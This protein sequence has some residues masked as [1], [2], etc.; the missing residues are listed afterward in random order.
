[1][2]RGWP[3]QRAGHENTWEARVH[4][5]LIRG[6]R[7]VDGT[8]APERSG[9]VAIDGG[10]ITAVGRV[11][12]PARRVIEADGA[13]V[14][15]GFVDTHSHFDGQY[16]WDDRLDPCFS[17]GVTS[18]IAGNCGVGFAPARPRDQRM[19]MALMEG[20]EDIPGAVLEEGLDWRWESFTD[21][22]DRIDERRFTMDVGVQLPHAPLRVYVMGER[23]A[24]HEAATAEDIEAMRRLLREGLDAGALGFSTGR[25]LGHRSTNGEHPPGTFAC[26]DELLAM[27]SVLRESGRGVFQMVPCGVAGEIFGAMATREER[28]VEH[29]R[30]VRI[31][32]AANRP[33]IYTLVQ[34]QSDPD[35]WKLML[36]AS[37]QAH[38]EG[39][40]VHPL[41]SARAVGGLTLLE[42]YHPF[43]LR[44]A[45][46]EIAN[47]PLAERAAAMR[48]P[49][50]RAA[51][52][53][54]AGEDVVAGNEAVAQIVGSVQ[55]FL[56]DIYL[57][58]PPLDYEP[59]PERRLGACA[60]R[61]GKSLEAELYDH[62]SAGDGGGLAAQFVTNFWND[63]L[64]GVRDMLA[65]PIVIAGL[66]DAGAHVRFI[67]DGA[68]PSFQLSFWC[69]DRVRGPKLPLEYMV[70]KATQ[71]PARLYGLNDRGTIAPGMRADLNVIDLERLTIGMPTMVYDLPSGGGRLI[72]KAD[73]YL[74]TLVAGA[75]TREN[76]KETGARPGRLIRSAT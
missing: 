71:D 1:M 10:L 59:G 61:S 68:L 48:E 39:A 35:D 60:E 4:D 12:G 15:P 57:M 19:L 16:L 36:A 40:R 13:L 66:G 52:L 67:C 7:V 42:G 5:I 8:G 65:N 46:L 62:L 54:Q 73:G 14:T 21:Y 51:I 6:G 76:D 22:L 26:D 70:R 47:L 27:A 43:L 2:V 53:G 72:Q 32:K 24:R 11:E 49:G 50:R 29:D 75:V 18:V 37:E 33:L 63:G 30:M 3:L 44:P 34:F 55:T 28:L 38:S 74:A 69:R 64:E 20:V 45:Y 56:P 25:F 31:A 23:A 17:N 9:D 58:S 41:T